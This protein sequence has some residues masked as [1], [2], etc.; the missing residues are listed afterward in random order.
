MNR[1]FGKR[2]K[3]ARLALGM[4]RK[5]L[6]VKAGLTEWFITSVEAGHADDGDLNREQLDALAA[7][8]GVS[9]AELISPPPA[10]PAIGQVVAQRTAA[11]VVQGV[12]NF[13]SDPCPQPG[14]GQ[15]FLGG[16]CSNGHLN[17]NT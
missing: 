12:F 11:Y 5:Y 3:Q 9:R 1:E 7:A 2:V 8:L 10:P 17:D 6:A 14:C 13:G 16:R 4:K 15:P